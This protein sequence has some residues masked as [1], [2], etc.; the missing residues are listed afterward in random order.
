MIHLKSPE[1]WK[2][3]ALPIWISPPQ[4]GH[5]I[6]R[7]ER[8]KLVTVKQTILQMILQHLQKCINVANS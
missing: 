3:L 8:W 4:Y 1:W 2:T 5:S 7:K 6:A